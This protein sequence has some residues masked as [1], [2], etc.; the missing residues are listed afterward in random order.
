MRTRIMPAHH[1]VCHASAVLSAVNALRCA[2]TRPTAGPSGIDA[3]SARHMSGYYAML[4]TVP[5]PPTILTKEPRGR[6]LGLSQCRMALPLFASRANGAR[7][8]SAPT[9]H[10]IERNPQ[11]IAVRCTTNHGG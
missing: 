8:R 2:S 7:I 10:G 3:A 4:V 11:H 6:M 9:G 1:R 5:I